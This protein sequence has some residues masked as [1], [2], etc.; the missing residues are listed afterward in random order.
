MNTHLGE[1]IE[2]IHVED[3]DLDAK[4]LTRA[5]SKLGLSQRLT[6]ARDGVEA[7]EML[8]N[9]KTGGVCTE[10][11]VILLDINMPR[12]NGIE[13]L[14]ELRTDQELRHTPVFI[15][16]TSDR[17][18][19]IRDAYAHNVAGYIVKP[20]GSGNFVERIRQWCNFMSI[21]ELPQPA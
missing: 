9:Q 19:D 6:R 3:S 1:N 13:F 12:M 21:I 16:T 20:V 2:L 5:F 17:P 18:S 11:P 10:R 15:L 8:R 14:K 4:A 7:L